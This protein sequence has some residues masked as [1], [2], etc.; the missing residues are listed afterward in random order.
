MRF[1]LIWVSAAVRLHAGGEVF[2]C[3]HGFLTLADDTEV[4]YLMGA[5][6]VPGLA[7]GVRWNDPA[8]A[9]AWPFAPTVISERDATYADF[10]P[11]AMKAA[12]A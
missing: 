11:T 1:N 3:A 5:A 9:I 10:D 4:T 8:F 6:Y 2:S 12:P 7:R